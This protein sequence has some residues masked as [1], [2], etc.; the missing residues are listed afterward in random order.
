MAGM[1]GDKPLEMLVPIAIFVAA[2]ITFAFLMA[3]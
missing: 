3:G 2:I 1:F